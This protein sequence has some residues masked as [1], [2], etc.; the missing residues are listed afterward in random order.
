MTEESKAVLVV[1]ESA[2]SLVD[3]NPAAVLD[4]VGGHLLRTRQ[5]GS[6]AAVGLA[7]D[8]VEDGSVVAESD[9]ARHIEVFTEGLDTGVRSLCPN[10]LD[11]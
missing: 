8:L 9:E 2:N 1:L 11:G 7:E 10:K 6:K 4:G 3:P 5:I